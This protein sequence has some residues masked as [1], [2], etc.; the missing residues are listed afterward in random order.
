WCWAHLE[1]IKQVFRAYGDRKMQ[2]DM[3]DYDDLLLY[4]QQ[5]LEM[6]GAGAAIAGR[7]QHVLVDE[8][9]DTNPLQASILHKLWQRLA[10]TAAAAGGDASN[11][12]KS[13]SIMVVGDDAQSIYS[14]RGAT[15]ENILSFPEQFA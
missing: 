2:R 7:F 5:A 10:G 4:W 3:L 11:A 13:H 15:V 12:A 1:R 14:F 9:Q 8:Y 6:D